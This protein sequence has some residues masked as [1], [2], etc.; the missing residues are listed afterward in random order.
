MGA[1]LLKRLLLLPV[2]LLGVFTV[3]F[4]L[5][6]VI[7]G[8]PVSSIVGQHADPTTIAAVREQLGLDQPVLMQYGQRLWHTV[9]GDWGRS[10]IRQSPVLPEIMERMPA[11]AELALAA[12]LVTV[13]FGIPIG[14]ISAARPRTLLD[15]GL[16]VFAIAGVSLPSFLVGLIAVYYFGSQLHWL[17]VGGYSPYF[18]EN[19]WYLVLPAFALGLRG[20]AIVA[21]LTRSAMLEVIRQD[22]V[23]TAR[24]KGLSEAAVL[25]RHALRNALIP[26]VTYL[27][28]DI[29]YLLGG[30]VVTEI[31]FTWPGFGMLAVQALLNRD[32]PVVL[33]T[34]LFASFF[35]VIANLL[36]DI[37][38][39]VIDPRIKLQRS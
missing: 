38:Y 13:V 6:F 3:T 32:I 33:G 23:R 24:A 10:F 22:Y 20:V 2:T 18:P 9:Q 5:L 28:M 39:T 11:T 31:V 27:G 19:L 12:V 37:A 7:P 29:G 26:I 36:T 34:V 17:P 14:L 21:R 16:M 4:A 1:Y 25:V 15:R 30:A 35:V 8:D